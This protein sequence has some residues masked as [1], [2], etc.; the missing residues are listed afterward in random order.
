MMERMATDALTAVA[1]ELYDLVPDEFTS[2]RNARAKEAKTDD[3][4]LADRITQLKKPSPAAWIVNRLVREHA[5]RGNDVP[6][7]WIAAAAQTLGE[8]L[9]AFDKGFRRY[10]AASEFTLL[11]TSR[12]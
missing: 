12:S 4:E 8:H 7:V 2:A 3:R 9:A 11:S 1:D 5:P 6:D 10:L